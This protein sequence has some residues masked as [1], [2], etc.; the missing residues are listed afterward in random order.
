MQQGK[1]YA[2]SRRSY[3]ELRPGEPA[4]EHQKEILSSHFSTTTQPILLQDIPH[5]SQIR[6]V[7]LGG[8]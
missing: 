8:R 6:V 5:F 4:F 2:L 3:M 7:I 1:A